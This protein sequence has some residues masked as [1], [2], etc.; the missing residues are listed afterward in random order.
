MGQKKGAG[1]AA[2][3]DLGLGTTALGPADAVT[4]LAVV[5]GLVDAD[6]AETKIEAGRCAGTLPLE[7][8]R[9]RRLL[10]FSA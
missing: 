3:L 9:Q 1:A 7:W 6:R 2:G 10:G 4:I 8:D 5:L